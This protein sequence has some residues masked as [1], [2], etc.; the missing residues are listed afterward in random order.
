[1][2][3]HGNV[4]VFTGGPERVPAFFPYFLCHVGNRKFDGLAAELF[5]PFEFHERGLGIEYWHDRQHQ[6]AVGLDRVQLCHPVV[7]D[8]VH[9]VAQRE[10][11]DFPFTDGR[12]A[13]IG[14]DTGHIHVFEDEF[15]VCRRQGAVGDLFCVIAIIHFERIAVIRAVGG[16]AVAAAENST[17]PFPDPHS[18][19]FNNLR[20]CLFELLRDT[21]LPEIGGYPALI[22]VIVGGVVFVNCHVGT[23]DL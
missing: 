18:V 11:V 14:P 7:I 17:F 20:G 22:D 21:V 10:V 2:A 12:V 13:D 15:G 4:A 6:Q 19:V 3:A 5:D 16:A 8:P 9:F 23:A 1:M